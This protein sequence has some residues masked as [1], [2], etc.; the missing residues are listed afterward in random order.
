MK[1]EN[2]YDRE[3]LEVVQGEE[4][5]IQNLDSKLP[6]SIIY[7]PLTHEK[8]FEQDGKIMNVLLSLW[9]P[10]YNPVVLRIYLK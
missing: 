9:V 5:I 10:N 7:A 2:L 3:E 4:E 8:L 1:E 6:N